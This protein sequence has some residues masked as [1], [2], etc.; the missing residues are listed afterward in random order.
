MNTTNHPMPGQRPPSGRRGV[1]PVTPPR[2]TR[3]AVCSDSAIRALRSAHLRARRR[4]CVFLD[5]PGLHQTHATRFTPA[6]PP[7]HV[8]RRNGLRR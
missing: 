4:F 7:W 2:R 8:D 6:P 5:S 3:G 1:A